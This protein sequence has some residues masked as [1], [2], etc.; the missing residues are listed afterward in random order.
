MLQYPL[1]HPP[2][3]A[4]SS[5]KPS[6]KLSASR[7]SNDPRLAIGKQQRQQ[8][9][10]S[11]H[12]PRF[13]PPSATRLANLSISSTSSS[14]VSCS[15]SPS[16]PYTI[17]P[18]TTSSKYS[19]SSSLPSR[20]SSTSSRIEDVLF[21]GDIVAPGILLQG[22]YIRE[23]PTT[24]PPPS[25]PA[26]ELE[27]VRRL[28]TG[29][30]A[31][32]YLVREVLRRR[33][34]SL[35]DLV[36]AMD[37][38]D[39]SSTTSDDVIYG[40]EF[41]IK[42]LSK[43]NLDEDALASQLS[44]V[45]IHQSLRSHP[46][47]VTL[48]RTLETPSFLLLLLEFVP[49][50]DLF[51]FLEQAR[52][53]CASPAPATSPS[54]RTPPTPSLLSNLHPSQ[55]L[56]RTRLRLVARMFA[57]MCDAVAACHDQGVFHRDIKPENFIVTDA[58]DGAGER[59]VVVKLTDFGLSTTDVESCDMDCGSAPY[60]SYECRNNVAPTYQPRAADVWSLGIVLINMLYHYN[61]WTDTAEGACP[62]FA[63]Y[64]QNPT[65]FFMQRFM[66]MTRPVA[67]FLATRV[68]CILP[69]DPDAPSPRI[70]AREFGK[71]VRDLPD[72]LGDINTGSSGHQRGMSTSSATTGHRLSASI[73]SHRPSS[74][75]AS[76]GT[77]NTPL[78]AMR[79]LSR[80]PSLVPAFEIETTELPTV[81]DQAVEEVEEQ[82][83][84]AQTFHGRYE[85][86][87]DQDEEQ[88]HDHDQDIDREQEH[89]D[90]RDSRSQS[91]TK[92]R[93]RGARKGKGN[94]TSPTSPLADITGMPNSARSFA[95]GLGLP[96]PVSAKSDVSLDTLAD[97]SQSLARE[98]SRASRSSQPSMSSRGGSRGRRQ[99]GPPSPPSL[100]PMPFP[101]VPSQPSVSAVPAL[102]AQ[103]QTPSVTKK[104]SKWKLSFGKNSSSNASMLPPPS[105]ADETPSVD[106]SNG[107]GKSMSA[108]ASNV[109]NLIMGLNAPQITSSPGERDF[110]PPRSRSRGR[111]RRPKAKAEVPPPLPGVLPAAWSPASQRAFSPNNGRH[112][113][114]AT[115]RGISPTSTRS[116][117]PLASSASS[118]T[119][120]N[121]RS[122]MSTMSSAG[123][124]TSAFTRFSNSSKTSVSTNATSVSASSWRTQTKGGP[125]TPKPSKPVMDPAH[126]IPKNVKFMTGTPW[127]LDQL[128]RHM[129]PDPHGDIFGQPPVRKQRAR[130]PKDLKLDTINERPPQKSPLSTR[131]DAMTSTTELEGFDDDGTPKKV[132]KG[133]INAL[134]KMLSALRR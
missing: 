100:F 35:E 41:A 123:T 94:P 133:Q 51:Y 13:N 117:R 55:L 128:P 91:T 99:R 63:L 89:D 82:E 33:Q 110:S 84:P 78:T 37:L 45:S 1:P 18:N 5:P 72:L 47:I 8:S 59:R 20:R 14:A 23:V 111:D 10:Q 79:P 98:I 131:Q 81:I 114:H 42:C 21:P 29:S 67:D 101:Y 119:S 112:A 26:H 124:S 66:G 7:S 102:A 116:G 125:S 28:G 52:D 30:Y 76:W 108:T 86:Y 126:Q 69:T 11:Q 16:S 104:A 73:P 65:A 32:V 17:A 40:R 56:A 87:H 77:T 24:V 74:R 134:A 88:Y 27:V 44:E 115:E 129:H 48:H 12:L 70:S 43:A 106:G 6:P 58:W 127:E 75:Q 105:P 68:F 49:G 31:V 50:E 103:T 71:W 3:S 90:G 97:A 107:S 83:E 64:L 92:R 19:A 93:K 38:P 34:P 130:K 54:S 36:G 15:P 22:E 4:L 62:S 113:D 53:H 46:N 121:W 80:A 122:S 95:S 9:Q 120:G 132:Q 60:M 96:I 109:T 57:Q 118:T 85:V 25:P 61:P 2:L 39:A